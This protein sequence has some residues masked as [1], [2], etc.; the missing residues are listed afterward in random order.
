[1][2][3]KNGLLRTVSGLVLSVLLCGCQ[4][5][6]HGTPHP[7]TTMFYNDQPAALTEFPVLQNAD[8][9]PQ[10]ADHEL[11]EFGRY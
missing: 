3:A 8:S 1:M 10:I 2:A 6:S 9:K 7:F 4:A 11:P 5:V